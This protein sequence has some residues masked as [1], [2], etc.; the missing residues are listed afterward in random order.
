[1]TV[2]Q[3]E[4]RSTRW[5][6]RLVIVV[7]LAIAAALAWRWFRNTY[8]INRETDV[9]VTIIGFSERYTPEEIREHVLKHWYD[10]YSILVKFIYRY[11]EVET[12]PFLEK[13]SIEVGEGNKIKITAY[14]KPPI[15]CL[16]DMG[17][18]LYFNRD[19]EIVSSR[20]SNVEEL[21]VV[22]GLEY[23]NLSLYQKFETQDDKLF[24]IILGIVFQLQKYELKIDEIRFAKDEAVT[25]IMDGNE[26][27]LGVRQAYD[28]QIAMIPD[29]ALSLSQRNA[30][31]NRVAHYDINMEHVFD[32]DDEFY[33]KELG[34]EPTPTPPESGDASK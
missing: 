4:K 29:V 2:I 26:Y 27:R 21:P 9:T 17:F 31:M 23:T 8:K 14:E 3:T 16:Y 20:K 30:R 12:L 13:I 15:A 1:M 25:L 34:A 6:R 10:E 19:G 24:D 11:R 22:T 5:I 33:A 28:V 32:S 7:V 18:Y